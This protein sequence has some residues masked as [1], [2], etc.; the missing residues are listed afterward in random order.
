MVHLPGVVRVRAGTATPCPGRAGRRKPAVAGGRP[1]R[2]ARPTVRRNRCRAWRQRT[3]QHTASR[4][5]R[6]G[7]RAAAPRAYRVAF[8]RAHPT[9]RARPGPTP[10]TRMMP[11]RQRR[12]PPSA[13]CDA[14]GSAAV[15]RDGVVPGGQVAG[16]AASAGWQAGQAHSTGAARGQGHRLPASLARR[17]LRGGQQVGQPPVAVSGQ[18]GVVGG[19]VEPA[20]GHA[21]DRFGGR[22]LDGEQRRLAVGGAHAARSP[23][24]WPVVAVEQAGLVAA[25]GV[26]AEHAS[27]PPGG[28]GQAVRAV[29]VP[30]A[31]GQGG[32]RRAA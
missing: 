13:S 26:P 22:G 2:S 1:R 14:S 18:R 23:A 31:A 25:G 29:L 4:A 15:A 9:R 28:V 19:R 20:R 16:H 24:C 30:G 10:P 12:V 21:A 3:E 5:G 6:R 17:G 8:R 7:D 32:A 27:P 11:R